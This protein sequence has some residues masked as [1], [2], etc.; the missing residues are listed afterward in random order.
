MTR[1]FD[2]IGKRVVADITI[3]DGTPACTATADKFEKLFH[4]SI[5]EVD[6]VER[7]KLV[8]EYSD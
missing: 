1:Y 5:R 8:K 6:K 7:D 3:D 2:L 4:C